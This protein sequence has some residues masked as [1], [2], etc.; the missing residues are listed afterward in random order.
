MIL[1]ISNISG[2]PLQSQI[3]GQIK[4][5]VLKGTIS[6]GFALP[7]IRALAKDLRV[8]V[9]TTQRAYESLENEGLIISQPARGFFVADLDKEIRLELARNSFEEK[10]APILASAI[11][12][13]LKEKDIFEILQN[14]IKKHI[15]TFAGDGSHD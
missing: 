2:E 15:N 4:A 9:I 13:G 7:S 12:E 8:S 14:E 3:V 6:P 10:L 11:K 1:E 5:L